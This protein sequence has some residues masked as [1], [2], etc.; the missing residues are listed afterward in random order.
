[1][2]P[3]LSALRTAPTAL[4]H[5]FSAGLSSVPPD[6]PA[7]A[8]HSPALLLVMVAVLVAASA[9][10]YVR[11]ARRRLGSWRRWRTDLPSD[12]ADGER[13]LGEPCS[14][15]F[16]TSVDLCPPTKGTDTHT[17]L[18][19]VLGHVQRLGAARFQSRTVAYER[20]PTRASELASHSD[21]A[22]ARADY[23]ESY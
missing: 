19:G 2:T 17:L 20:T 16:P 18:G 11:A 23:Y 9:L 4:P 1:M 10:A 22:G 3:E 21:G 12:E 15:P 8:T 14:N 13:Q 5:T 6:A 7:L